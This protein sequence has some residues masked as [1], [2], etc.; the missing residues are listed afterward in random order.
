MT[1]FITISR[2]VIARNLLQNEFFE[3][4]KRHF[5]KVVLLTT[6]ADDER[7]KKEF[8]APNVEILGMPVECDSLFA[9]LYGYL[10]FNESTIGLG[11]YWYIAA[12]T[13]VAWVLKWCTFMCLRALFE[14]LSKFSSIRRGLQRLDYLFLQRTLVK[15]Y[16]D[17]IRLY[18]PDVLFV[19][20]ML[21]ESALLKAARR[22]RVRTIGMPKTWDNPSKRYFA[23]RADEVIAWSPFMKQELVELHDYRSEDVTVVGVPQFDYY[24]ADSR[25][26]SREDFCRR[27]RL[28]SRKK[29]ICVGSEGKLTPSDAVVAE[30]VC[31]MIRGGKLSHECQVLIRPHFAHTDDAK[32]FDSLKGRP[33]VVIDAYNRPSKG[34]G[35][36]WDYSKAQMDHF[37]SILRHSDVLLNTASTLSLDAAAVGTPT[38]LIAFDGDQKRKFY[39]SIS[40]W[41]VC[42]YY[43]ELMRYKPAL[44]A[45][46]HRELCSH[47][48]TLLGNPTLLLDNQKQL[49]DRMCYRVDGNSGRRLF[50]RIYANS[51]N[52]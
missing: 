13:A 33:G 52:D 11:L 1:I 46:T 39:Q 42:N 44:I 21:E 49:R 4:V 32:K 27:M 2:G 18:K 5:D 20:N 26:E 37:L 8:D 40:R 43:H 41:Y 25:F 35:D 3:L 28:D 51:K 31:G 7:F 34:F 16:R 23:A 38:V 47:L 6:A 48:N 22:E 50:E 24:V 12:P 14:P 17:L 10:I 36:S 45:H 29:I 15:E 30:I 19:S 9:R